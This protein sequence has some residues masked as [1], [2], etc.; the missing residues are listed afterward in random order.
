MFDAVG[1]PVDD[2]WIT[3]ASTHL[4]SRLGRDVAVF[5]VDNPHERGRLVAVAAGSIHTRLPVPGRPRGQA[6]YIQWV[7]TEPAFRRRGASRAVMQA[8]LAWYR[9]RAVEVVELH[10]TP[11]GGRVYR[12]LGF[13]PPTGENLRLLPRL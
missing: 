2:E 1:S 12:A 6:G 9:D 11:D 7:S 4:G 10:A 8:L 5:V 3:A 13:E